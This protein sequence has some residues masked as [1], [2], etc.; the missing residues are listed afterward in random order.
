MSEALQQIRNKIR[1]AKEADS[2]KLNLGFILVDIT[3]AGEM[4]TVGRDVCE[5][6]SLRSL[7]L[8]N[9]KLETL[10]DWMS[11]LTNLSS[12]DVGYNGL[13]TLPDWM[14]KLTNLSSL[15]VAG[16]KLETLP[17]WMSKLTN[18]SSLYVGGN[19][20]SEFPSVVY[21]ITSL[22][23]LEL[24]NKP[25]YENKNR[26][27]EISPDILRLTRLRKLDL[28]ENPMEEPPLEIVNQGIEA[29][30]TYF[31]QR[32]DEGIDHI[33]EAKLLILG[34]SGAGKTSLA[35][36]I[37]DPNYALKK[38]GEDPE[39]STRGIEVAQWYFPLDN[40]RQFRVNIW[41]FG[42]QEIYH[43]THQFFLTKR[44]L[45]FL[46]ADNR[47]E[48]TDFYYWLNV[49]ELLTD[50][51]PLLI[52]KNEKQ[53]RKREINEQHLR[54]EFSNLEKILETNLATKRGLREILSALKYYIGILPH[55]GAALPRTWVKVREALDE[56]ER[57]HIS[58]EEYLT[59]CER[60]GFTRREDKLQLSGYLHD[61]GV[62]LHFQDDLLLNKTVILK[63]R[64]GTDAAYKVLD[65]ET[66]IREQGRFTRENLADIWSESQYENMHGELLQLMIRFKLCYQVP[67]ADFYIAPQ[68]LTP[69]Q[70]NYDWDE[71]DNLFLRYTYD[72]MPKGILT[73]LIVAMHKSIAGQKLVWRSGVV[74]E[75][76]DTRA[77]VIEHYGKK[78]IKIRVA[79]KHKRDL[80]TVVAHELGE[81]HAAYKRL[82]YSI[83]IPCNCATC[84]ERDEPHS[85]KFETLRKFIA[86]RQDEI[87]CAN[88][89]E[90]VNVHGLLDDISPT[91]LIDTESGE[92]LERLLFS[93]RSQVYIEKAYFPRTGKGDIIQTE[94]GDIHVPA[95]KKEKLQVR[96][97]WANGSFFL[98]VFIIVIA[99]VSVL[100]LSVPFYVLPLA[101]MAAVLFIPI[102]GAFQLR[103][104]DRLGE[105]SF[106]ELMKLTIGQ[107]PMLGKLANKGEENKS[108]GEK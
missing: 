56:D 42:G 89:Y 101:L 75:Q 21:Q 102:I 94:K 96:S 7:D 31:R 99:G 66:V 90:M 78:E 24:N 14:S 59:V 22:E 17:D 100:A 103:Q 46:V 92:W 9:N 49:V 44:S 61:L 4:D 51:S 35:K 18:L 84:K 6:E 68:L 29:I 69:N 64:W 26:I 107:L 30:R 80:L 19:L 74:F 38:E 1:Q 41:D 23:E 85:Y 81:I 36:K 105:K 45:Y 33:Y 97:A 53:D 43:S 57:D 55:V 52:I 34:E 91:R 10:P 76:D 25:Y 108:G 62:C 88:S 77:E 50:N 98:F 32:E 79:G 37:Q 65:N 27:K 47:K 12:L 106:L 39:E 8:R 87:Q 71:K 72:F 93:N 104:D 5:L 54:G 16:N 58:L 11:K 3:D 67:N 63:P 28:S 82:K 70:V 60:N 83:W 95:K 40:G 73:Q 13:K 15:S 48:D 2:Q 86:D 20:F